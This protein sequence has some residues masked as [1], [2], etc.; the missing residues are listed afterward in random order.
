MQKITTIYGGYFKRYI[1]IYN[2]IQT[3]ERKTK[4][5]TAQCKVVN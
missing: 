4:E 1:F 2:Y 5:N 3:K